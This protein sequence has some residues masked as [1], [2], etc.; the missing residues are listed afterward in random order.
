M[1]KR[2][3]FK[4]NLDGLNEEIDKIIDGTLSEHPFKGQGQKQRIYELVC[5]YVRKNMDMKITEMCK[6][7]ENERDRFL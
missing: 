2:Y 4:I 6:E 3:G 5:E 7:D 1:S